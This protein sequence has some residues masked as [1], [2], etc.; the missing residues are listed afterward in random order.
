[1]LKKIE[2]GDDLRNDIR[3]CTFAYATAKSTD[4]LKKIAE[5]TRGPKPMEV[6]GEAKPET[7]R[8]VLRAL[9]TFF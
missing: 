9:A 8:K 5:A 1:L 2:V 4:D 3:V 7:V 6:A